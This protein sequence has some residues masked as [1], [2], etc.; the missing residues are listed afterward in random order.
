MLSEVEADIARRD[1]AL[2]GLANL[3]DAEAFAGALRSVLPGTAIGKVTANY[4]KYKPGTNCLAGFHVAVN[5]DAVAIYG[6]ALPGDAVNKLRKAREQ[7]G[8]A[9]ALGPGRLALTDNSIV[10]SVFPNDYKVTGLV[11]LT[12]IDSQRRLLRDLMPTR[13][14]L[15]Q[16]TIAQLVYK[17]E[18]RFVGCVMAEGTRRAALKIYTQHGYSKPRNN[19]RAFVSRGALRIPALLGASD[20]RCALASAWS[21]GHSLTETLAN[22]ALDLTAVAHVGA[23]LAELHGQDPVGLTSRQPTDT[24]R[25]LFVEAEW[26]EKIYPAVAARAAR[27]VQ[28]LVGELDQSAEKAR[29]VHG[30]FHARQVLVGDGYATILDLDEAVLGEPASDLGNFLAHL[31]REIVRGNLP[32]GRAEPVREALFDGYRSVSAGLSPARVEVYRAIGLF[33]LALRFFRYRE[34][35]WP[36]RVETLLGE[37]ENALSSAAPRRAACEI[38]DDGLRP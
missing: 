28:R 17:P 8:I 34:P 26:L 23:A 38:A 29:P 19:A 30:D 18:R 14:D 9:G 11:S 35:N 33:R 32:P 2:P 5:G 16:G 22:E 36:Q 10:V 24:A 1:T 20:E 21:S 7:P 6:K 15:W 27:L 31:Q 4:V 3:L 25:A 12:D 13:R 37:A